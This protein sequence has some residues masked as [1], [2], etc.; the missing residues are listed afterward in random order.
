MIWCLAALGVLFASA[1]AALILRTHLY[2]TLG[3]LLAA[4]LALPAAF[5]VLAG[6][7]FADVVV[8]W[9]Q[10]LGEIRLGLDPLSAF[11]AIPLLAL[12]ATCAAYGA[13]YLRSRC[14][15]AALFNVL[16]GAMLLV[17][18]ARDGIVFLVAWELMTLASYG[19]V[20]FDH[21]Q[22]EVRRAG[23]V[24]L[25]ASHLGVACILSAFLLLG[26]STLSFA[27]FARHG[28]PVAATL[29]VIGFGVKAGVVPLHVWLPEAH[30][31]APSHVSAL[32]S[33]VLIKLGIYGLLRTISFV[34]AFPW[35]PVLLALGSAGALV[36]IALA[37]YQRDIKRALAY[38][39]VENAGI[40]L[41]GLGLGMWGA[42][43]GRPAIAALGLAGGLLHVWNH[44]VVKCLLFLAAGGLVHGA[45]TRDLEQMGGLGARMPRLARMLVLGGVAIAAL[46]PLGA[47]AS[48]WLIYVGLLHGNTQPLLFVVAALAT[49]GAMAALC[50]VRVIG[51]ALLGHPRSRAAADA[52]EPG[53]GLVGPAVVL[54]ALAIAMPFAAPLA[55]RAI[56]PVAAQL[57]ADLDVAAV[58]E[59]L[60]PALILSGA[61]WLGGILAF[62]AIRR[63]VRRRRAAET[64]G[65]GYT[66]PSPRMQ[67]TA[68]SFAEG[69]H[70]LLPR[71]L[72]AKVE[73]APPAELFPSPARLAVDRRDP[74][75]RA[76]YEPL[77]DRLARRFSQLRWVQQGLL[78]I[79]ILYVV[80]AV[81]LGLVIVT[82]RDGWAS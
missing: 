18:L 54:A 52:H 1:I 59:A 48:E 28:T 40:V 38:S 9:G 75:T 62:L 12:G 3:A 80:I 19:L 7:H 53:R 35:G 82:L 27:D 45:G 67:Y 47:F 68:A 39:T 69:L 23:W 63:V 73:A 49:A 56:A 58:D 25:V 76:A 22:P 46:P 81:V 31:A 2:A 74:F 5:A 57:G 4:L 42:A 26:D 41:I 30:A 8:P 64:W 14:V 16:A 50:F 55:V 24:Y 15:P 32:M 51:I 43:H 36:G 33:A 61:V 37:F 65:C 21:A 71:A 79:Y 78:H 77:L 66:A 13:A 11:F 70:R 72:R 20:T 34:P 10:P 29:A 6:A 17:L 60:A 44:A